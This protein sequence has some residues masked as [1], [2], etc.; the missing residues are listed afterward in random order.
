M[1][2]IFKKTKHS[3]R[4]QEN[5]WMGLIFSSHDQ[6]CDCNNPI[7]HFM[8]IVNK[9]SAA[10][11]PEPE[12]RNIK[13]L[14]TGEEDPTTLEEETGIREGDLDALFGKDTEPTDG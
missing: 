7:L 9:N 6:I 12:I 10:I 8:I 3:P 4:T 13:C 5:I 14:L 2:T 11:K 1:S